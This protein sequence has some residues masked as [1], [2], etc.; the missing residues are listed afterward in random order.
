MELERGL[1]WL[2]TDAVQWPDTNPSGYF[3]TTD[4]IRIFPEIKMET[5]QD[6]IK[7]GFFLPLFTTEI[8]LGDKK[9]FNRSQ[10]CMMGLFKKLVDLGVRRNLA[11]VHV[12]AF[13]NLRLKFYEGNGGEPDFVIIELEKKEI[14]SMTV[15]R[16]G[17]EITRQ[18]D[19]RDITIIN[20][21]RI[22]SKI[23]SYSK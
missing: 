21:F 17:F 20:F 4:I 22:L 23:D 6:W 10:V 5:V 13:H 1:K 12:R 19:G 7:R 15:D 18:K 9:W 3:T 16:G 14:G 11:R 8:G 2:G